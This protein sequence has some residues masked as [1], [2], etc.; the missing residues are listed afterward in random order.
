MQQAIIVV[1][2][3][4]EAGRL[5]PEAFL[6]G[7]AERP[8]LH[9]HFVDDGSADDTAALLEQLCHGAPGRITMQRMERN[10]GKAEA[11][12]TGLLAACARKAAIVGFLDADLAT[13]I[14]E[15]VAMQ[16]TLLARDAV[17]VIGSRVKLL[18]RSI[19]RRPL[20]HLAGRVFASAASLV[21]QMPVYDTQC[22]AKVMRND[23]LLRQM[24]ARP[25]DSRWIF[26]VELLARY[27]AHARRDPRSLDI[28]AKIVEHPVASW[29]DV[30]GSRVDL[31]AYGRAALDLARIAWTLHRAGGRSVRQGG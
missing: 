8:Q 18:G 25:F 26:D 28:T 6:A 15:I 20:R 1:P 19:E 31:S 17:M 11:V 22:G 29:R 30:R 16:E 14:D 27:V 4:N 10:V 9:F 5:K 7:I 21:L 3:Y 23:A 12:R 24:L 13:P 2:C